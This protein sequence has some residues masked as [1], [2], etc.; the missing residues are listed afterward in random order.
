M[1]EYVFSLI[2]ILED[3]VLTREIMGQRKPQGCDQKRKLFRTNNFVLSHSSAKKFAMND[4]QKPVFWNILPSG[5]DH[6]NH[7][8]DMIR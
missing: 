5:S 1:P 3:C 4:Q 8:M 2:L 6:P 7:I